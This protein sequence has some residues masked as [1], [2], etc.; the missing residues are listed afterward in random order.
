METWVSVLDKLETLG[1]L[2]SEAEHTSELTPVLRRLGFPLADQKRIR[3]RITADGWLD[4]AL[5]PGS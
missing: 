5:T 3:T 4:L 2:E 1:Q